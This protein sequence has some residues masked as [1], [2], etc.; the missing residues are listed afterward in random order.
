MTRHE[1][2]LPSDRAALKKEIRSEIRHE[3][4]R[5]KFAGCGSCAVLFLIALAVPTYYLASSVAKTG[6]MEVPVLSDRGI[7]PVKPSRVV[8]PLVGSDSA[9]VVTAV[10]SAAVYDPVTSRMT[11]EF[12][13]QQLTTVL[14]PLIAGREA[15]NGDVQFVDGQIA[16]NDGTMELY[17]V[18][19]SHGKDTAMLLEFRPV[20]DK[21]SVTID[22][23]R[24]VLGELDVPKTLAD[25]LLSSLVGPL[26]EGLRNAL[27]GIGVVRGIRMEQGILHITVDKS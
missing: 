13:E 15:L 17:A 1:T 27:S 12:T 19:R 26:E 6:L 4:I 11:I 18:A 21:G 8:T 9:Q 22:A 14:A 24:L 5:R 3:G 20:I 7:K 2:G 16:I 25:G 23:Q 10:M